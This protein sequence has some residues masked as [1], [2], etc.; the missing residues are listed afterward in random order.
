[1]KYASCKYT[2]TAS[3]IKDMLHNSYNHEIPPSNW[4]FSAFQNWFYTHNYNATA[5]DINELA[6]KVRLWRNQNGELVGIKG[7]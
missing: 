2:H 6:K 4:F 5:N 7:L 1:M 3:E